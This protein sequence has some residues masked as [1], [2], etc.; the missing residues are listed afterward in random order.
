MISPRM[1]RRLALLLPVLA[2]AGCSATGSTGV[3]TT[4]FKGDAKA[5][6]QTLD[7]LSSAARGKD[8]KKACTQLLS[9][10][11][12]SAL[13]PDCEKVMNDQFDDADDFKL[14]VQ[15]IDVR[16]GRATARVKSDVNGVSRVTTLPLVREGGG[17]RLDRLAG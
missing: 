17:W 15:S 11:V 8:G 10:A 13:G 6:A 14:D 1:R 9:R 4:S 2:L 5:V 7:S 16:G 3:N 12:V